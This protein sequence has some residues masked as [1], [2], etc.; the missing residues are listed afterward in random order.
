MNQE[1]SF[2]MTSGHE[3]I[4][5]TAMVLRQ[6]ESISLK[7][8]HPRALCEPQEKHPLCANRA[9]GVVGSASRLYFST[10]KIVSLHPVLYNSLPRCVGVQEGHEIDV[11]A[12]LGLLCKIRTTQ[13]YTPVMIWQS[14]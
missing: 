13:L 10:K 4:V 8:L 9:L 7:P 12:P 3:G 11:I 5:K 2:V 1:K 14:F 6:F